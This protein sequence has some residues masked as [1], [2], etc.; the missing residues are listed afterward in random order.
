LQRVSELAE[1][2][3]G[4]APKPERPETQFLDEIR[5]TSG[6]EQLLSLY[7]RRE[8]LIECIDNWT[9]LAQRIQ[10]RLPDWMVLKPLVNHAAGLGDADV[11]RAQVK[12]IEQQRQLLADPDP[13]APLITSLTQSLRE[14]LNKLNQAYQTRHDQGMKR[15]DTDGNWQE[16]EP[17]QRNQLLSEQKL[18]LA[19]QPKVTVQST[20]EVLNTLD[21]CSLAGFADQV[22]ALSSRFD[23]VAVSAAELCEPEIQFVSV[24]RRTLKTEGEID[25]WS[26]EVKDQL[27]T[28]LGKG[29][30]SVK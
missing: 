24:P 9:S 5:L 25:A 7:N 14:A 11:F 20:E 18:T 3:G 27:K 6:N 10:Q 13:I 30:I 29:P 1:K 15:L 19:D 28:A 8:E 26:E 12:T 16:L 17:E 4:D 21:Q 23:N 2:A 22:A